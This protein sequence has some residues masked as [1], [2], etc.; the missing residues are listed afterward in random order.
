MITVSIL[1][2]NSLVGHRGLEAEHGLS[3]LIEDEG[4]SILFDTGSSSLFLDNAKRLKKDLSKISSVVLSHPHYDHSGGF[5]SFADQW[6]TERKR[7]YTGK[8]FFPI[9][10][11]R[12][13]FHIPFWE[14]IFPKRI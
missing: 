5:L 6:E 7:L 11:K 10:L 13:P 8:D 2:E 3:V 9:A 12:T 1:M 4:H 14:M